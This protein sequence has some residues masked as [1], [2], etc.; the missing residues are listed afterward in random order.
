MHL[1]LESSVIQKTFAIVLIASLIFC[2]G[3]SQQVVFAQDNPIDNSD[4]TP[5]PETTPIVVPTDVPPADILPEIGSAAVPTL[6]SPTGTISDNTPTYKWTKVS[7]ASQYNLVAY[8]STTLIYSKTITSSS[9]GTSATY[10]V[11]TPTNV[12]ADAAYTWKVRAYVNNTWQSFSTSLA[13]KVVTI[14]TISSPVGT[15]STNKPTYKWTRIINATQYSYTLY[16]GTTTVYSYTVAT[17]SCGAS[18]LTCSHTPSVVLSDGA[19]KWRVRAYVG[20][21]WQTYTTLANFSLTTIPTGLI[22]T[23]T[24]SDTTPTYTW[25]RIVNATM[26]SYTLYKGSVTVYSYTVAVASCGTS[27]T[28]CSHTPSVVLSDGAYRWRVR[29]YVSGVWQTYTP[30]TSFSL[31]SIPTTLLPTATISDTTPTYKWTRIVNATQYSYSL[32]KGSTPIYSQTV[33]SASCGSST[34]SCSNTPVTVLTDGA[35][36][37]R[38]RAYVDG[39][40]KTFSEYMN[41]NV[42]TIPT[43]YGPSGLISNPKPD[44]SWSTISGSTQYRYNVYKDGSLLF[45]N[46]IDL[47]LCNTTTCTASLTDPLPNGSYSWDAT[48]YISGAW[49]TASNQMAF[50]VNTNP[51]TGTGL[52][53]GNGIPSDFFADV[54]IRKAFSYCFDWNRLISEYYNGNAVQSLELLMPGMIGYDADAPHYYLDLNQAEAEFKLADLDHDGIA[55]GD[56]IDG[57]DVWN[58]GFYLKIPYNNG[59]GVRQKISQVLADNLHLVNSKFVT[60]SIGLDWSEYLGSQNTF[61]LPLLTAG[62]LEDIHDPHNWYQPYTIGLFGNR[63]NMPED[64]KS[65]FQTLINQ[66]VGETDPTTRADIYHQL[67]QLYYDE[68][69]GIP[70]VLSTSHMIERRWVSG[71]I[72]NPLFPAIYFYPISKTS[73]ANPDSFVYATGGGYDTLDPALAY[74]TS[75]GNIIQNIYETLI[76]YKG[77]STSEFVPQLA[78][79]V[80]TVEN[81]G[82]SE[83]GKTI[84]FHIRSGVKFSNEAVL[85]PSDV[86][87]SFQRGILQGG[88]GSPQWLFTEAFFGFGIYDISYVVDPSGTVTNDRAAM[89]AVDPSTLLAVCQQVKD[90]IVADDDAGTVTFHLA[91]SWGPLMQ[92]LAQTWGSIMNQAWVVSNGG[93]NGSCDT[94]Q[95]YYA[96]N[97]ADDPFTSIAM[98]TGPFT[99]E[100]ADS[101]EI[102]LSRNSNYWRTTPA[103]EGGPSGLPFL[104]NVT[105]KI[106]PDDTERLNLISSGNAD[107]IVYAE[108]E[109]SLIGETCQ[110]NALTNEFAACIVSDNSKP[111]R[112]YSGRPNTS[113]QDVIIY[114]FSIQ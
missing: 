95:N 81:G 83:D 99:L 1:R 107:I 65:Q 98:G 3:S 106:I 75:S 38:V 85:T 78:T 52:L 59:N 101:S 61:R 18:T 68:N 90:A 114:N 16:K 34:L 76:F 24:I 56:E 73:E 64:L 94:W 58:M 6:V 102:D 66:G 70:M 50:I 113:Q 9:C 55:A 32:Y 21:A 11:N 103:Y 44:F 72:L 110:W 79:E 74:D 17:A 62:W 51:Y 27:T 23:G 35:Y 97:S 25:S 48:A 39:A 87:Y 45:V 104:L 15:I 100:A 77:T 30:L 60:E 42:L 112:L 26:Y 31:V 67:N 109:N 10:C 13:F 89:Q 40:W 84:T 14:P 8:K 4:P 108:G 33:A 57:S 37:W 20:G 86:A 28:T 82:I 19:Y 43:L 7:G 46:P 96:M 105:I 91:N 92:T 80:P 53:D 47:S 93:W 12:L 2:F 69:P 88:T 22:P 29:A 63:Q 54:H 5:S 49:Q 36:K 111:L 71:R 41:F